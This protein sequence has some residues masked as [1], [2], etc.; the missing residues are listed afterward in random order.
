VHRQRRRRRRIRA[1]RRGIERFCK[2]EVEHLDR[3]VRADL[4][5][6]RLQIPVDDALVVRGLEGVG[7]LPAD[8]D[9]VWHGHRADVRERRT[10]DQF[11]DERADA[12]RLPWA[13]RRCL[14]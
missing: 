10:L 6:R 2:A 14:P 9:R 8:R 5:V 4:D 12:S 3:A 1:R 13:C 11:H 7:N